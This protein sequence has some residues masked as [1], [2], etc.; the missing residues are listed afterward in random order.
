MTIFAAFI[1]IA[2]IAGIAALLE[3]NNRHNA[4]QPR[5]PFGWTSSATDLW[6]LRHDLDVARPAWPRARLA[7][8]SSGSSSRASQVASRSTGGLELRVQCR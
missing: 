4:G 5:I 1:L 3:C 7:Q 8:S 2:M 6:R